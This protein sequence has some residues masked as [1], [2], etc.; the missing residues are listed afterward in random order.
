[1]TLIKYVTSLD[2]V[3]QH[4]LAITLLEKA[5]PIWDQFAS[6]HSLEYS[7]SIVGMSHVIAKDI[8]SRALEVIKDGSTHKN[9][10]AMKKIRHEFM[11][12][13]V[14][15]QDDDWQLPYAV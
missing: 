13:M 2:N 14:A 9:S 3:T 4:R 12:P 11:E 5:I 15:L 7:D 6:E 10:M 1:M 8:L